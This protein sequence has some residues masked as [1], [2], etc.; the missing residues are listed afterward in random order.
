MFTI[1]A[2]GGGGEWALGTNQPANPAL[3]KGRLQRRKPGALSVYTE[4]PPPSPPQA[5]KAGE[6]AL[7]SYGPDYWENGYNDRAALMKQAG[8]PGGWG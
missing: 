6:P 7:Y 1:K 3:Q 2:R 8:I 5:A 4:P